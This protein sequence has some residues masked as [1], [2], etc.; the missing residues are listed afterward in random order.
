MAHWLQ[1]HEDG[2]TLDLRVQPRASCDEVAGLHGDRLRL[3]IKAPPVDG[4][5]NEHLCRFIAGLFGVP[6]SQVRLLRGANGRDKRVSVTGVTTLPA[7]LARLDEGAG[8]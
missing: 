5:A 8:S 1:R 2:V 6:P 7:A 3:R 4:A